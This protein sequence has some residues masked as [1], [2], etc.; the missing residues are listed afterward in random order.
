MIPPFTK[1]LY[2]NFTKFDLHKLS[3]EHASGT[4]NP[5]G[6]YPP[7]IRDVTDRIGKLRKTYN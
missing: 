5:D 7:D 1:G 6:G 2:D 3:K 4:R